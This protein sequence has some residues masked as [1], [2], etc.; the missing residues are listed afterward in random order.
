MEGREGGTAES[1]MKGHCRRGVNTYTYIHGPSPCRNQT[2]FP[3]AQRGLLALPVHH[4]VPLGA[5]CCSTCQT[6]FPPHLKIIGDSIN[7][8]A[9]QATQNCSPCHAPFLVTEESCLS[10][11][12]PIL[13]DLTMIQRQN[14]HSGMKHINMCMW[15]CISS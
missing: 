9:K 4:Y 2:S 3:A 11:P 1:N 5:P 14:W 15:T 6:L 13:V 8:G 10:K 7:H 12:L